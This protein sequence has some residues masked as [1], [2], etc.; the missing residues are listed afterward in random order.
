MDSGKRN[1]KRPIEEIES[2]TNRYAQFMAVSSKRKL[3]DPSGRQA[4]ITQYQNCNRTASDA[5]VHQHHLPANCLFDP[6][7]KKPIVFN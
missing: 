5:P 7:S 2:P 3:V 4:Q 1:K 6:E